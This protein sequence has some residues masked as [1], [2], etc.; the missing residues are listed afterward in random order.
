MLH[1]SDAAVDLIFQRLLATFFDDADAPLRAQIEQL[2]TAALHVPQHPSSRGARRFAE[3][4]LATARR[5]S[6]AYPHLG[7][8][9]EL[10]H[11]EALL[12]A[13]RQADGTE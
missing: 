9:E 3:A 1:P 6:A 2:R 7:L 13:S 5:L 11:F 12:A 4:Q 10:T 8:R